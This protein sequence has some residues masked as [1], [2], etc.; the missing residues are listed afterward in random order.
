M[1]KPFSILVTTAALALTSAPALSAPGNANGQA[2]GGPKMLGKGRPF[3]RGELPPGL[4][5]K[6]DALSEDAK[7]NAREWLQRFSFPENDGYVLEFGSD[8]AVLYLD[9]FQPGQAPAGEEAVPSE[10]VAPEV[11]PGAADDAFHLHSRPGAPNIVYL[12]FDGHIISGTAWNGIAGVDPLSAK[13]FDLDGS[14]GT[15]GDA[16]HNA[17]AEIWHRV[18][19]DFAAFDIDV[20]TEEPA[21]FDRYTGRVLVTSKQDAN[22]NKM[23]YDTAGAVAYAGVWGYAN[24]ASYYSPALIYF[25]NLAKGT[26]YIAESS[27]HEFGHNLGLS[28]DG[29]SSTTYY[30][31]HGS[32]YTSW[33]PIMGNSYYNNVTQWSKGEYAGA[34]N[35]Q[36]DIE[37]IASNL[38]LAGDDHGDTF[39]EATPLLVETSG[40]VLV[41]NPETDPHNLYPD[42]KGVIDTRDD[43]DVFVLNADA[44]AVDLSI[45]PAWDAFY[46]TSKR[47]ANLDVRMVLRDANGSEVVSSDPTS[48]TY[49]SISTNVAAGTYYLEVS[50]VGNA[51]YSDYASTGEYFVS[52]SI[53]PST[54]TNMSPSASFDTACWGADCDFS[55]RSSDLD[56]AIV[57]HAWRFGDGG[58]S[59]AQN[60]SHTYA[61]EGDYTV[62]LTVIDNAGA[63]NSASQTVR[64]IAP[65]TPPMA[66]FSHSCSDLICT[67]TDASSD[68]DGQIDAW[69]W[70]FGDGQVSS[71]RNPPPH[72]YAAY[73]TYTVSLTVTDNEGASTGATRSVQLKAPKVHGNSGGKEKY[74]NGKGNGNGN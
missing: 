38:G 22:G 13:P 52:G 65:N 50:G 33:A 64:V 73:G 32:G 39:S 23:P 18:A 72:V 31:G 47:G 10:E 1:L 3:D 37:I 17:I 25:D 61:S 70:N 8:G 35:T 68:S 40:D 42:N 30:A 29:T 74:N 28:H 49:A 34:N 4:R 36:D 24:Y 44:G 15:F 26:T 41:T 7:R 2:D 66:D 46:R 51:N 53:V 45:I 21:G 11:S 67:F 54:V 71:E 56:G 63:Q 62:T 20:T 58:A 14:P 12:D 60:P 5:K 57:S 6:Y 43:T 55:D 59:T 16:E 9:S 19:E 27:A 48:D 69:S